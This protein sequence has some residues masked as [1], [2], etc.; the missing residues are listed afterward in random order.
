MQKRATTNPFCPLIAKVESLPMFELS[1]SY[2]AK[3]NTIELPKFCIRNNN[4]SQLDDH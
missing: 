3:K 1:N 4:G 2:Q